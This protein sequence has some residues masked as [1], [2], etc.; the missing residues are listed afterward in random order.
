M[1]EQTLT[2]AVMFNAYFWNDFAKRQAVRLQSVVSLGE[3]Y[4][5]FGETNGSA[6]NIKYEKVF[7]YT[8]DDCVGAG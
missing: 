1:R 7:R 4:V 5:V 2:Y 8:E 6:G 3:P